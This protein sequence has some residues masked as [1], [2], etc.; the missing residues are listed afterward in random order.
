MNLLLHVCCGPCSIYPLSRLRQQ[1]IEVSGYFYNPNIHPFQEFRRR[2]ASLRD[3]AN[4]S[5][6]HIEI[7]T[8]YGLTEY[9][10]Q[11]VFHEKERCPLCYAMRLEK[12]AKYGV[13]I[14]AEAFSTTLLYSRFQ[15]H[16]AIV[17]I[18]KTMAEKYGIAFHYEDFR[19]GWQ[20][21]IDKSIA[22]DLYRQPYCGCIYSEQERY[23]KKLRKKL[24]TSSI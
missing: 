8:E 5:D 22:M 6:F 13:E 14:G 21:G 18:G 7:D 3:F 16:E 2:L 20:E 24:R 9:L 17:G 19:E 10:Q 4:E 1:N 12:T 23:D 15:N 11:V